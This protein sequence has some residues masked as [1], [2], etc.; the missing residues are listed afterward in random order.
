M[1]PYNAFF[2]FPLDP[3]EPS[4]SAINHQEPT[5]HSVKA[6]VSHHHHHHHHHYHHGPSLS[7][8]GSIATSD[9]EDRAEESVIDPASTVTS[10]AKKDHHMH[11]TLMEWPLFTSSLVTTT[12][13]SDDLTGESFKVSR[14]RKR[15][16]D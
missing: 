3:S 15:Q 11:L 13:R 12:S 7:N 1:I 16:D 4:S 2:F 8:K 14:K 5:Q 6:P 9:I 10:P